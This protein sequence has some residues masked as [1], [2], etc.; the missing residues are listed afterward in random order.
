M[1]KL[2]ILLTVCVVLTSCASARTKTDTSVSSVSESS[3]T[4]TSV[5]ETEQMQ[6]TD[7]YKSET[8]EVPQNLFRI[9]NI[10][11]LNQGIIVA[12]NESNFDNILYYK[13]D[14]TF[15]DFQPFEYEYP[16]ETADYDAVYSTPFF[17]PDGSFNVI[18]T[19]ENH[20]GMKLPDEM[21]ENFDYDTYYA[22]CETSY[23]IVSYG[24]DCGLLSSAIFDYPES[25]YGDD[26]YLKMFNCISDGNSVILA[27]DDN[28]FYRIGAD[29]SFTQLFTN[30]SSA[31]YNSYSFSRDLDG[32]IICTVS[33]NIL[34]GDSY[35]EVKTLHE[36]TDKG[37][38]EAFFTFDEFDEVYNIIS[39]YGDYRLLFPMSDALYG[40]DDSSQ[41]T[42]LV[43]WSNSNIQSMNAFAVE[44][45][46]YIGIEEYN[47]GST[48]LLRLTPRDMSEYANTKFITIAFTQTDD[49]RN[50]EINKIINRFNNFQND[51]RINIVKIDAETDENGFYSTE[52][53]LNLMILQ[54]ETPD[55]IFGLDYDKFVNYRKK[56]VFTDLYTLIDNDS[57]ISREDFLPNVLSAIEA[58][59][60]GLYAVPKS[61]GVKTL[62]TKSSVWD[63][64]NWTT[65]EFFS[66]YDNADT[67][68]H[69]YDGTTNIEMLNN[70]TYAMTDFVD[71]ENAEC[72]FDSPEF[73]KILEFC[74]RFVDEIPKPDKVTEPEAHSQYYADKAK[75]LANEEILF[76][77]GSAN[78]YNDIKTL[79]AG[80]SDLTFAGYPSPDGRGGLIITNDIMCIS[81][82]CEEKEGAWEFVKFYLLNAEGYGCPILCD[83]F[84]KYMDEQMTRTSTA[85]GIEIPPFDQ[86]TRDRVEEYIKS[87]T[88]FCASYESFYYP[89]FN[90]DIM[91]I[92]EEEAGLYFNGE[93]TAETSAE[94]IQNRVSV[95]ISERS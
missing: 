22:N 58:S 33:S 20:D 13:T 60:G 21:D 36:F 81:T 19:L 70:M 26:G 39:G 41:L 47:D 74:N 73:I 53:A 78:S 61:F 95:L 67:F 62:F 6:F 85:N 86:Q 43:N 14:S 55:I 66:A 91:A 15:T 65:D 79:Y 68:N 2:L 18:F 51:Y 35:S 31:E 10:I 42:S 44:E 48:N 54:G 9:S 8:I 92:M 30:E 82:E 75:W 50:Q 25:L 23:M 84:E 7:F 24:A 1:K 5:P 90:R 57:E 80:D 71:Y 93:Q 72:S 52:N 40:F 3:A 17:N 11:R 49:F 63:K 94:H 34:N 83:K 69:L 28:S 32:K 16:A 46:E 87:A 64:E 56:D 12:G 89:A 88:K 4:E 38:S 59:D 37:L 29:G 45:N 27:S 76:M 77:Q